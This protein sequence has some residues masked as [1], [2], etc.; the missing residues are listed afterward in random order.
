VVA[1]DTTQ[2]HFALVGGLCRQSPR[3]PWVHNPA[4]MALLICYLP[5]RSSARIRRRAAC[6]TAVS[7]LSRRSCVQRGRCWSRKTSVACCVITELLRV[8]RSVGPKGAKGD[9]PG[10]SEAPPWV[11][12]RDGSI[13]SLALANRSA[14]IWAVFEDSKQDIRRISLRTG[15]ETRAH[16]KKYPGTVPAF[17]VKRH[18]S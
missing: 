9:S 1:S 12:L 18:A 11:R 2:T 10:Q 16:L 5:W 17:C 4:N 7:A 3:D 8:D 14:Q 15:I 13:G 6:I